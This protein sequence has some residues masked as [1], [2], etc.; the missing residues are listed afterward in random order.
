[1]RTLK[2]TRSE[3]WSHFWALRN[4]EVE[5]IRCQNCFTTSQENFLLTPA[6][7]LQWW[8]AHGLCSHLPFWW[9][10][11][12]VW[13]HTFP[14]VLQALK[15]HFITNVQWRHSSWPHCLHW[16][17]SEKST[18]L[19]SMCEKPWTPS[20]PQLI[21]VSVNQVAT[22]VVAIRIIV[23]AT[24]SPSAWFL[25]HHLASLDH[26]L[27]LRHT[28][29]PHSTPV[30]QWLLYRMPRAPS[31]PAFLPSPCSL[32]PENLDSPSGAQLQ[33]KL[34]RTPLTS[35]GNLMPGA[36]GQPPLLATLWYWKRYSPS[37]SLHVLILKTEIMCLLQVV[38]NMKW[39]EIFKLCVG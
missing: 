20:D 32:S 21:L 14:L 34:P 11:L 36:Q 37:L 39:N 26:L 22:V 6:W 31:F 3:D 12:V 24:L 30:L 23:T 9:L 16:S 17:R 19:I 8:E 5:E 2:N 28:L 29:H 10:S 38:V 33:P 1:M 18:G 4:L 13:G 7:K 15:V 35:C 25:W 27:V